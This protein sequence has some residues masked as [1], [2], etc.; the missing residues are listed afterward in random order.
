MLRY[1][2]VFSNGT[3]GAQ[4]LPRTLCAYHYGN[5]AGFFSRCMPSHNT[6][7]TRK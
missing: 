4:H 7:S 5:G 6:L 3:A 2:H 1:P